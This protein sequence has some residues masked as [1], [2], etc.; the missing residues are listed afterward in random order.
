MTQHVLLDNVSHKDLRIRRVYSAEQGDDVN[1]ARVF[2]I[3]FGRLQREYPLFF[4]KNAETSHFEAIAL[5]GFTEG[6]N[7][8]LG[9]GG[10]DADYI[11]LS[12]ERQPFL[13][14]FQEQVAEGMPKQVPVVHLDLDHPS[15]GDAEGEAVFLPQ[16]GESPY[17]ARINS[18]LMTIHQGHDVSRSL[19]QLLVGLELV[20][21]LAVDIEFNDGSK[22][23]LGGLSTI[24]EEKFRALGANAL[25]ELHKQG[26]L[27]SIFMMLA[28]LLNLERLIERKNRLLAG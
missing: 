3:E 9:D 22:Q 27:Q 17:L 5:L 15:V 4:V 1:V 10:W 19:S 7:L 28:S 24:N 18:V 6:E 12:I 20:E 23:S 21:S 8:Y 16:G 25:G 11:P 26:H 14:G 2:P 13:I